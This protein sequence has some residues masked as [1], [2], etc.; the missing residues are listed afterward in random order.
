MPRDGCWRYRKVQLK[1]LFFYLDLVDNYEG[2]TKCLCIK[3]VIS[4]IS[5]EIHKVLSS[6]ILFMTRTGN[7]PRT[8]IFKDK[9]CV[10][11][12]LHYQINAEQHCSSREN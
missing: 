8:S 1:Q 7:T 9:F 11:D 2:I 12:K 3:S 4:V 10:V 6:H 5:F